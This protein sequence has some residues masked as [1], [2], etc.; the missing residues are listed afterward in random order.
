MYA[1]IYSQMFCK[2]FDRLSWMVY[3]VYLSTCYHV[4]TVEKYWFIVTLNTTKITNILR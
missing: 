3:S 1:C 4:C 2:Q